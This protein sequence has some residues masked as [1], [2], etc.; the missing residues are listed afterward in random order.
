MHRQI[1]WTPVGGEVGGGAEG[2]QSL[3]V[4]RK[5]YCS[6]RLNNAALG[7][8]LAQQQEGRRLISS[9]LLVSLCLSVSLSLS[10]SLSRIHILAEVISVRS[11]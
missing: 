1:E 10:L 6:T 8:Y 3:F 9:C 4:R 5:K 7:A 11:I 2:Q